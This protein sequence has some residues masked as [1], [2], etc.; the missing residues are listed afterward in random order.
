MLPDVILNYDYRNGGEGVNGAIL[1]DIAGSRIEFSRPSG[2][3]HRTAPLFLGACTFTDDTVLTVATK[4][5][6]LHGMSYAA[7]YGMF[8]RKYRRAGYGTMFQA[9]LDR[10][11]TTGYGSFGNG[12]AMRVCFIGE[13]FTSLEQVEAEAEKSA[14]CTHNH[15]EGIR[16]AKA[17]AG[18]VFLAKNGSSK[19]EIG[20]FFRHCGYAVSR[21]LASYRPFSKFDPTAAASVPIAIRCFLESDSWEDC[22]RKVFSIKC[23]TDTVACMAGGI[24]EAFYGTTGQRDS[25]LLKRYLVKPDEFGNFDKFL[26]TAATEKCSPKLL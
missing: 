26:Y 1:G 22:I 11:S 13:Y 9:W 16:S 7:A 5:A 6:L 23:D 4:Y 25:E 14:S 21:P 20:R 3:D 18:A 17:I 24:A 8:G 15:P 2:F 19:K 10:R 12:A